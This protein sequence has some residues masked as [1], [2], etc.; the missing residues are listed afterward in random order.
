MFQKAIY[1]Q[2]FSSAFPA[3]DPLLTW[4]KGKGLYKAPG[5]QKPGRK[6]SEKPTLSTRISKHS[7][8]ATTP[9]PQKGE[10]REETG[11]TG[12][13]TRQAFSAKEILPRK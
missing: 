5:S 11:K 13:Q 6:R 3:R 4:S 7:G 12:V 8:E 10:Q 1:F 9:V 2:H